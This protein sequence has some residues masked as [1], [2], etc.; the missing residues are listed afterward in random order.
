MTMPGRG[1]VT[2]SRVS[3]RPSPARL[4]ALDARLVDAA[5]ALLA[6]GGMV[7]ETLVAERASEGSQ[8]VS[9]AAAVI[10]AAAVAT[11]RSHGWFAIPAAAV[12][13]LI[14]H[15]LGGRLDYGTTAFLVFLVLFYALAAND[16]GGLMIASLA[17]AAAALVALVVLTADEVASDLAFVTVY[18]VAPILVGRAL[19]SRRELMKALEE[20][21]RRLERERRET[22]A[23]AV[24][25]ERVRIARELHDVV[26][27]SV[28]VMTV[29]A[30]AAR[31]V[32]AAEPGAAAAAL[33]SVEETGRAALDEMRRLLGV[34][35][36]N[37]DERTLAPQPTVARADGLAGRFRDRG[38]EVELVVEGRPI[39]LPPASTWPPTGCSR[40]RS[41][42]PCAT[43][44][45]ALGCSCATAIASS[46]CGWATTAPTTVRWEPP[47]T[48]R[49]PRCA[50]GS[51]ST[52]AA[53]RPDAAPTAATGC[54]R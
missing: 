48:T 12:A 2:V 45:T 38:L 34:L 44:R 28:S 13:F 5:L 36:R 20:R 49:S 1:G 33:G 22:E 10:L 54:A 46:S 16:D 14:Q 40:R 43:T 21:T 11:R 31:R 37:D 6:L 8:A 32:V 29:Q 23:R 41:R 19:R 27:H 53:S 52:A 24:D 42:T 30:S 4:G 18:L 50:S 26:T 35:R 9:L 3:S 17:I 25:D 7:A 15:V 51:R 47:T 39:G